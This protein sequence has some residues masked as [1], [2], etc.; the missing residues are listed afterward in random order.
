MKSQNK[1]ILKFCVE[2]GFLVDSDLLE[3][4]N[5]TSDVESVKL[6]I[7]RAKTYTHQNILTKNLFERNREQLNKFFLDLPEENK[8]NLEG[9]RIKLGLSIEIS[10]VGNFDEDVKTEIKLLSDIN[11]NKEQDSLE[12]NNFE[13]NVNILSYTPKNHD[14]LE[15]KDF[16]NHFRK[17][18]SDLKEILQERFELDNLL[19]IDKLS[20]NKRGVSVIGMV[21]NKSVTKNK[22]ILLEVEDLTGRIKILVSKSKIDVYKIAEEICLDSVLGFRCSGDD[23]IL[24]ANGIFFPDSKIPER[25][26][27]PL[28]EYALFIGD[29]HFGS[30]LFLKEG[31]FRFFDYLTGKVDRSKEDEIKKIKYLFI[32][33]DLVTGVGNY[34]EQEK[35]LNILDLEEQFIE[36]AKILEKIPK[37]IKII[38]S[39]GNHDGVR[40]MEPQPV[41]DIKYAWPLYQLK[42]VIITENPC[43]LNIGAQDNFVG[44]DVLTYHGFSYPYYA[45]TIPELIKKKAMNSPEEIMKY[46]LKHRHL[47]PTHGST[48]SYPHKE[49][50]LMIKN[51]PDI[52]VSGHT[53][54]C[55]VSYY[56][57]VLVIS[58]SC[59]EAMTPYQEKFGNEPDHCK[60]PMVNLKT[61]AVKILD[62]EEK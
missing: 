18:F 58:T 14:K 33:G 28:E 15:V 35:D 40:I 19:S 48:Q 12:K 46:L 45:G 34:P 22:N 52:F 62:F 6:I 10:K 42:N 51:V 61:R 50:R 8:K 24:F 55:G 32:T 16:V 4:F 11:L 2:K 17:R 49:D 3:L 53:H 5:E 60:V 29:L 47:A 39:P 31:F 30:K 54:K 36:L 27:S 7:E 57:N 13:K 41:F 38:I 20:K 43:M 44:F 56:N 9:L 59:W 21:Y 26:R 37:H 25:K 23:K 1:E